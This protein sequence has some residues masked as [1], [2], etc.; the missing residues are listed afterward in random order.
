M[1][2]T[3]ELEVLKLVCKGYTNNEIARELFISKHTAKAHVSSIFRKLGV[4][5]RTLAVYIAAK[6]N[7]VDIDM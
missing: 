3:R 5:H 2:T 6:E 1:L 4:N 7:M